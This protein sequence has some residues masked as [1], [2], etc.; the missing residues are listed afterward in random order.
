[1]RCA[2]GEGGN[3]RGVEPVV[4]QI[5]LT[6][7]AGETAQMAG[8][9]LGAGGHPGAGGELFAFL[10]FGRRPDV[11]GVRRAAPGQSAQDRGVHRDRGRRV[12]EMRVQL[13]DVARQFGGEHER[14]P[15]AADARTGRVAPEVAPPRSQRGAVSGKA[16]GG[17]PCAPDARR[18]VMQVLGQVGHRR[19]DRGV[20][21]MGL[22]GR[23]DGAARTAPG[24]PRAPRGRAAPAR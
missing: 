11:L 9:D 24:R 4:D 23:S 21:R 16:P 5:D 2:T 22:R 3:R 18:L 10:P 8:I 17:A 14:L 13:D 1:M 7:R 20:D 19:A 15:Q 12:Q 6:V